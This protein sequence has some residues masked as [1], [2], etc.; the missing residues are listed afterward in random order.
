MAE[1]RTFEAVAGFDAAVLPGLVAIA[2]FRMPTDDEIDLLAAGYQRG[3][4]ARLVDDWRR[5]AEPTRARL[6]GVNAALYRSLTLLPR[7]AI[8]ASFLATVR[9]VLA[10]SER[11]FAEQLLPR[12][13]AAIRT[14]LSFVAVRHTHVPPGYTPDFTFPPAFAR[15]VD[16]DD[17]LEAVLARFQLAA[18]LNEVQQSAYSHFFADHFGLPEIHHHA[19][20]ER[21]LAIEYA[22]R[23]RPPASRA[24]VR[25]ALLVLDGL[26]AAVFALVSGD[27]VR[28]F[29]R[30]LI[31]PSGWAEFVTAATAA[32]RGARGAGVAAGPSASSRR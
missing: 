14:R 12:T 8:R 20:I 10:A 6:R 23:F 7:A 18:V 3:D 13:A 27:P 19:E 24:L 25:Q 28:V 31:R 2:G 17:D 26:N 29:G 4:A 30:C 16:A 11:F 5:R 22:T 1:A 9:M 21:G 32:S 15:W